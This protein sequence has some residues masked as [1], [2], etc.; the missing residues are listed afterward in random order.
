MHCKRYFS[1]FVAKTN[2][3]AQSNILI[4]KQKGLDDLGERM[5]SDGERMSSDP[6]WTQF[7]ANTDR[8]I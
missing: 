2:Y 4:I 8:Q 5:S 3:E 6:D 7:P 1:G